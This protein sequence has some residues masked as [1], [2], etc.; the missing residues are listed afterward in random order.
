MKAGLGLISLLLA[1][2]LVG[3]MAMKGWKAVTHPGLAPVPVGTLPA[4]S[5][6]ARQQ[7]T[8]LENRAR[9]EVSK[10]VGDAEARRQQV[11]K[12]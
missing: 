7:A 10:A 8:Q 5:G 6:S 9:D 3:G 1:L 2:V 4:A 12:P 11:D